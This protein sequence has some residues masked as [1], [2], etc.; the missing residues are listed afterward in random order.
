MFSKKP[1]LAIPLLLFSLC[2]YARAQ[3]SD[4]NIVT[5]Q[6]GRNDACETSDLPANVWSLVAYDNA[7][8]PCI[9]KASQ[10]G[11]PDETC[12]PDT[13]WTWQVQG[14]LVLATA[15]GKSSAQVEIQLWAGNGGGS[16]YGGTADPIFCDN[17]ATHYLQE[18]A[19]YSSVNNTSNFN[20]PFEFL[21]YQL[22]PYYSTPGDANY[23]GFWV[24]A[25]PIGKPA[26]CVSQNYWDL[27][28][29]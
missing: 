23:S 9:T 3:L 14:H 8:Q 2:G 10:F 25:K 29:N 27:T 4:T 11:A 19:T 16:C 28:H 1:W 7:G 21:F 20:A 12:N 18:S 6:G 17:P 5:V 26:V 13:V 24:F 15:S 22:Q